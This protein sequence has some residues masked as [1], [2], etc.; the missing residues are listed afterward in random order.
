MTTLVDDVKFYSHLVLFRLKG[1]SPR[2]YRRQWE[3]YWRTVRVTGA[4]GEV[5]WDDA[6]ENASAEDLRRFG[7]YL[8]PDL[9]L[10]DV[11]C[12]NGRQARFLAGHFKRVIGLDVSPAAIDL[13]RRETRGTAEEPRIAFQVWNGANPPEAEALHRELG[14]ANVYMR[15]VFHCVQSADRPGFVASL[16]TLLGERGT[17]YQIE[18]SRGAL[19]TLRELP[20]NSPSGLPH[21]VHKVVRNG[22]HPIGFSKRDRERYFP[23]DRWMV[24]ERGDTVAIKTVRLA[25][26]S[27]ALVPANYLVMRPRHPGAAGGLAGRVAALREEEPHGSSG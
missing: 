9:P 15:T 17:L 25:H 21:L 13:A 5:L 20:G 22:I 19:D 6:P 14:D 8:D 24:L 2:H 18:L 1:G 23:D 3:N 12:G 7:T 27:E 4:G 16:A 10:I 26:G 11:G